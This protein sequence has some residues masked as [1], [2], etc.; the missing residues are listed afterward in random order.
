MTPPY[1]RI[2]EL[3]GHAGNSVRVR[4]WVTHVRSSGKVAFV[5]M[6]DGSGILQVVLVKNTLP[7]EDWERFA[8][9]TQETSIE[10]A[11]AVKADKRAPGGVELGATSLSVLGLSP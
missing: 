9:L 3:P 7:P 11:G 1:S 6:R 10:V 5:V 4:G 8:T 2:S